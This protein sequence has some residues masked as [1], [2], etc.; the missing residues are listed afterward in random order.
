MKNSKVFSEPLSGLELK[1]GKIALEHEIETGD[2][3]VS[4]KENN[5]YFVLFSEPSNDPQITKIFAILSKDG[6]VLHKVPKYRSENY[7]FV[8]DG[9]F[10]CW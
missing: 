3:I 5:I 9:V 6:L 8:S 10:A 7:A 4:K 2:V 1:I